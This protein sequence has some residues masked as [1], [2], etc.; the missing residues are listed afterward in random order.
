MAATDDLD[1]REIQVTNALSLLRS[2][3]PST[4]ARSRVVASNT[5]TNGANT[6]RR[7]KAKAKANTSILK[8][9]A[10][11]TRL[12]EFK[13]EPFRKSGGKLFVT[14]VEKNCLQRP[15]SLKVT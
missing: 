11:D 12:R 3:D 10:V 6:K 8:T 2:A 13:N 15:V 5:S 1:T 7:G 9:V 4:L 14:L